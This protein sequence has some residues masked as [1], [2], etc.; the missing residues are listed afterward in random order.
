VITY[1]CVVETSGRVGG[2]SS[3]ITDWQRE[4]GDINPIFGHYAVAQS[5]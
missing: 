5:N 1:K 4:N 2:L 3:I